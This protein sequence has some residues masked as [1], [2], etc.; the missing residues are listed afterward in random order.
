MTAATSNMEHFKRSILN[1]AAV[2]DPSLGK[3]YFDIIAFSCLTS[4]KPCF[5]FLL[6]CFAREI[7]TFIRVP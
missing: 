7:K 6:I 4:T 3:V 2:L 5:K 1:V